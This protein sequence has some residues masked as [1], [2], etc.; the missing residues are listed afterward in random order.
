MIPEL[1][2]Q[3]GVS[4]V[5]QVETKL[6]TC[7]GPHWTVATLQLQFSL[8]FQIPLFVWLSPCCTM[9]PNSLMPA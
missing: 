9:D 6:P 2:S 4:L 3:T 7:I 8:S 5:V 1:V